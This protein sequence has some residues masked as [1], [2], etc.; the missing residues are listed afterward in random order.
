MNFERSGISF[1]VPDKVIEQLVLESGTYTSHGKHRENF[2]SPAISGL[3]IDPREI[4]KLAAA[5]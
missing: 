3:T 4:W 5:E 1:T 2:D